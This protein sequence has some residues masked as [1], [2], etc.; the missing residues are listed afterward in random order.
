MTVMPQ[1][2]VIE[3]GAITVRVREDLDTDRVARIVGALARTTRE[4]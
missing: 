3:V 1:H 4:C 2:I